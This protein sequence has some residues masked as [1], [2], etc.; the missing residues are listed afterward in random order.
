MSAAPERAD[1]AMSAAPER[2]DG[3][4]SVAPERADG[5]MS[6][7]RHLAAALPNPV[8]ELF[9]AAPERRRV[10]HWLTDTLAST[11]ERVQAGR[12]AP[13]V[14]L[15]ALRTELDGFDFRAARPLEEM[16]AW[17]IDRLEHGIVQMANPRY[18]GLFN[19]GASFPAQC[20]D[21]V[22]SL[23]NPQL[24]SS[25]SSPVPVE[26]EAHVIR[27]FARRAGL[28]EDA[29][30]HFATGGSEANFTALICALTAASP[31]FAS[32]GVR[33]FAGPVRFYTS[34]DCHIAWL[35][36]AHQAGVGRAAL[37]LVDTDGHGRLDA[38]ALARSIAEDRA[39]GA[40]PVMVVATAGTTG[41][42]MID[43]LHACADIAEAQGLWYH[44][45]AAWG[46][47]A[48]ASGRMRALLDGIERAQSIT[49]DAHK[50]LATTMG[51]ALFLTTRKPVLA[52][53]FH[54]ST[55]F[56]PSSL[57]AL[58]PYLN[59]VQWSRRFLG[60]RLFLTL[61]AAGWD[62]IGCHVERGV[63]VI[64]RVKA[65]LLET[66]WSIA[67]DSPLAVLAALP[68]AD[69]GDVRALVRRVVASGAAWVAPTAF[70][71]R[72]VVRICATNGETSIE[73]VEALVQALNAPAAE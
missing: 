11:L 71:G 23:F 32:D 60:L 33:A 52:E 1:G 61:A 48:L 17:T 34:R 10:E 44:V 15:A 40:V 73:D 37:R 56:M 59:S 67:N 62:G 64:E 57:A 8:A 54:A 46:G 4:M 14:D 35:K 39:L 16:L 2:A 65:R 13:T 21:R 3:P 19:P 49:I 18:F 26:L 70:E 50:W 51:C 24:A 7:A 72:D 31:R 36:I 20:A 41:A 45:D 68:P 47:A 43:P 5:A 29:G 69:R 53:A 28:P 27:A 6:A 12:V 9:P 55:S 66:G 22:A 25:A 42:G 38:R 58:D 63:A 30:G